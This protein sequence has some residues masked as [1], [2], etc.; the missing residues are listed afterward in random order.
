MVKRTWEGSERCCTGEED[1]QTNSLRVPADPTLHTQARY[2]FTQRDL[3]SVTRY[4]SLCR[5]GYRLLVVSN[6]RVPHVH[7]QGPLATR[8]LLSFRGFNAFPPAMTPRPA[9]YVFR[10][11]IAQF[12]APLK[13]KC[14]AGVQPDTLRY[15]VY[16][17]PGV[18]SN[19]YATTDWIRSRSVDQEQ[20]KHRT[21]L[22]C[23]QVNYSTCYHYNMQSNEKRFA[24]IN[25]L[26]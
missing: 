25:I 14:Q 18:E 17:W 13:R 6:S 9:R 1:M 23:K 22:V 3:T 16:A 19:A 8:L 21:V 26:L 12:G 24:I 5:Y 15:S 11:L 4:S 20:L 10:K 2:I 7:V